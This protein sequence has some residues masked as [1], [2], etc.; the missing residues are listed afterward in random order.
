MFDYDSTLMRTLSKIT[1]FVILNVLTLIGCIPIVTIGVSLS[2]AHYTALKMRRDRDNYVFRNY[3]RGFEM[4]FKQGLAIWLIWLVVVGI[5]VFAFTAY[6]GEGFQVFLKGVVLAVLLM[7]AMMTMWLFPLQS[8]FINPVRITILNS[9]FFACKHLFRTLAMLLIVVLSSFIWMV[10]PR[11]FWIPILI[12]FSTPIY[13]CAII[14]DKVFLQL[15]EKIR[16][17]QKGEE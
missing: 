13:L 4:N 9:F 5:S 10:G 15:E 12:G 8:K 7:I 17:K 16:N 3:I 6:T 14:Y 11:L 2:A 1:D